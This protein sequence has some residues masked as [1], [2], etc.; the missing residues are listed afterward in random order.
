MSPRHQYM[1]MAVTTLLAALK[2]YE[3]NGAAMDEAV[4]TASS[5]WERCKAEEIEA[6]DR[7]EGDLFKQGAH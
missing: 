5:I 3:R 4:G 6:R 2:P 1:V 7:Q